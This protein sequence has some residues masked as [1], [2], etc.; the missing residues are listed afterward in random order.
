MA[1]NAVVAPRGSRFISSSGNLEPAWHYY[2]ANIEGLT[3]D[4]ATTID[5]QLLLDIEARISALEDAVAAAEEILPKRNWR[6][7]HTETASSHTDSEGATNCTVTHG[8]N[9]TLVLIRAQDHFS[10][11]TLSSSVQRSNNGNTVV[12]SMGANYTGNGNS[13]AWVLGMYEDLL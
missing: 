12:L 1:S 4:L 2:L 10:G 5:G 6:Y 8:L 13:E 9:T 11:Q 3:T 7:F